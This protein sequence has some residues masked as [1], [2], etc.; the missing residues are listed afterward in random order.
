MTYFDEKR[1]R[2]MIM[3][4]LARLVEKNEGD[5]LIRV[6]PKSRDV[7]WHNFEGNRK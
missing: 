1:L 5:S 2:T 3:R 4:D 7:H 6:A